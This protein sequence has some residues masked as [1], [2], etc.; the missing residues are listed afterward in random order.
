MI[1]HLLP[2]SVSAIANATNIIYRYLFLLMQEMNPFNSYHLSPKRILLFLAVLPLFLHSCGS[3][4]PEKIAEKDREKIL[5]YIAEN[6]LDA[7]EHESGLFY[8]IEREGTGNTHPTNSSTVKMNYEG[9]Y[10]KDKDVFDSR[11]GHYADLGSM[12]TG[13]R[14]GIP[15]LTSGAKAILLVPSGLGYG[16]YPPYGIRPNACL[17]FEV[18][19]ID[20][21][22][23]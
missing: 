17:V 13:W 8:V 12:I 2:F 7:K 5:D 23:N 6:N 20:I 11:N 1:G 3:D 4:D 22:N 16:A 9:Y 19:I 18:E 10:L 15:L 21:I 14:I